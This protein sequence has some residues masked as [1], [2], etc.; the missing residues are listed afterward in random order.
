MPVLT[1]QAIKGASLIENSQVLV[2]IF[3]SLS[4]GKLG[5][6]SASSTRTDPISYTVG[7]QGIMVPTEVALGSSGTYKLIYFID[8]QPAVASTT[9][10]NTALIGTKTT[11]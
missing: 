1:E 2:A 11:R 6:A 3:S 4:I 8:A 7:G 10:R 9:C 5:I